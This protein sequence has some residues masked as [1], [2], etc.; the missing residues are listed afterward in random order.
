MNKPIKKTYNTVFRV[1][2]GGALDGCDAELASI[3]IRHMKNP[4]REQVMH[5]TY[6]LYKKYS[7]SEMDWEAFMEE[8]SSTYSKIGKDRMYLELMDYFARGFETK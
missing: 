4:N 6:D 3:L 2:E 5:L 7:Q 8:T 1:L